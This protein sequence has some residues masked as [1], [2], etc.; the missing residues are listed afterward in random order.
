MLQEKYFQQFFPDKIEFFFE[1]FCLIWQCLLLELFLHMN[2]G[3]CMCTN[4]SVVLRKKT[5]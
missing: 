3:D 1:L 2:L 4:N 5:D